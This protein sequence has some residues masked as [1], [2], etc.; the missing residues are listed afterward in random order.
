MLVRKCDRCGEIYKEGETT[1]IE[2]YEANGIKLICVD[3]NGNW[4]WDRKRLYD[5]CP[6]C[7]RHLC[8]WLEGEEK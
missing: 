7:L 8:A 3:K 4:N 6:D 5:L 1:E 2:G